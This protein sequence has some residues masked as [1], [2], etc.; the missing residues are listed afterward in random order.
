MK[1]F[2][3]RKCCSSML[4]DGCNLHNLSLITKHFLIPH[5]QLHLVIQIKYK[6]VVIS[7]I[8]LLVE[9]TNSIMIILCAE[10]FPSWN[11]CD[12]NIK[13]VIYVHLL[14]ISYFLLVIIS[15]SKINS[16]SKAH[17]RNQIRS[18][19]AYKWSAITFTSKNTENS[20]SM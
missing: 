13:N 3:P 7:N 8:Y 4:V 1:V 5:L 9:L 16:S 19:A 17:M 12:F 11:L 18:V 10:S 20:N 14:V 6:L 15:K 2:I